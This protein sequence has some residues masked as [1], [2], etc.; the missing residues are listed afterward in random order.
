MT[1]DGERER[2]NGEA[3]NSQARETRLAQAFV[4][5]V[6]GYDLVELMH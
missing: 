5:L 2:G 1:D 3:M 6:A 4:T